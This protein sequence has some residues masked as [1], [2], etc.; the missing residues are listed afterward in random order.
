M[1]KPYG[2]SLDFE[3]STLRIPSC[4]VFAP[5][6]TKSVEKQQ[7]QRRKVK[8]RERTIVL[9][10]S[11][12]AI[13]I[14]FRPFTGES[15][16]NFRPI[17]NQGTAYLSLSGAFLESVCSNSTA[18]IYYHNKT[19]HP[20]IFSRSLPIGELSEFNADT[21]AFWVDAETAQAWLGDPYFAA[22]RHLPVFP[23]P[24]AAVGLHLSAE[25]YLGIGD[26][27]PRATE[28]QLSDAMGESILD[29]I[30]PLPIGSSIEDIQ[31]GPDLTPDQL[32]MLKELVRKY[33]TVW[34]KTD[35]VVNEP[36]ENWLKI[37]VKEEANLKSR[38]VYRLGAKDREVVDELF[39]KL[40]AER[41]M[42]KCEGV[43]PVGWG[44][45]VVRTG[46]PSDKGRV[47]VDTRGLNA[48]TEDDAY[49]LPRQD[50]V[51]GKIR[52]R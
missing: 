25:A 17:H 44:V 13:P 19:D 5:S 30:G 24:P 42:S 1:L 34:E 20:V 51:M 32:V 15:D 33:R 10:Y 49:P 2:M 36:P 6:R 37:R 16:V 21:E 38:G 12:R 31:Y 11:R 52:W 3:S 7:A 43:N 9:P 27:L 4:N 29:D 45:F 28:E 14:K 40:V 47:V 48:A 35:G 39:D 50:D 8:V 22:E 46:R 23:F 41:K 18:A 26:R